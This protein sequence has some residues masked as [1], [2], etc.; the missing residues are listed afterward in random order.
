MPT[1][2]ADKSARIL[3]SAPHAGA[4]VPRSDGVGVSGERH[5]GPHLDNLIGR[6]SPTYPPRPMRDVRCRSQQL[7]GVA[8]WLLV[9]AAACGEGTDTPG[10]ST[11]AA[12]QGRFTKA[13]DG[14][15]LDSRTGL[16]WTARD[17]D[18][19]LAWE[20]ADRH[21]RELR[22]DGRAGWRLPEIGELQALYDKQA[23]QRCGDQRCRLDPAIS[24][25]GPY[26][27]TATVRFPGTRFYLDFMTGTSLSPVPN[28]KLVRRVLCTRQAS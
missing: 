28:P 13:G 6:A 9:A 1:E 12:P 19:S 21:C 5:L 16:E 18:Q 11:P 7:L 3:D 25:A 23:G 22:Q 14:V 17:H 4:S 24:L 2:R 10:A 15:V 20:D 27:W 26:V 8:V